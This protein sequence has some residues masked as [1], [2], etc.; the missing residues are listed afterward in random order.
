MKQSIQSVAI[1]FFRPGAILY[2]AL[3][4]KKL[5]LAILN[6]KSNFF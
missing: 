6:P 5:N 2:A 4:P 1:R 3:D